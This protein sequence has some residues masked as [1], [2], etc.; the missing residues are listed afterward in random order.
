MDRPS[1]VEVRTE[2]GD[3]RRSQAQL[4]ATD[5]QRRARAATDR[6]PAPGGHRKRLY[7]GFRAR[8]DHL[9]TADRSLPPALL[10]SMIAI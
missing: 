3:I 5:W 1:G 7:T 9:D 4:G 8:A 2:P 10:S 6:T